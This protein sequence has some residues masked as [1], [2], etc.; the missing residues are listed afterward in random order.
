MATQAYP[1]HAVM[2]A[3]LVTCTDVHTHRYELKHTGTPM[4]CR[5][6]GIHEHMLTHT[7]AELRANAYTRNAPH[8]VLQPQAGG[9]SPAHTRTSLPRTAWLSPLHC[10][11]LNPPH[12]KLLLG[13]D[14]AG[15]NE[16][17]S[18]GRVGWLQVSPLDLSGRRAPHM[19]EKSWSFLSWD[20][21][22]PLGR[23][24]WQGCLRAPRAA[25]HV[26]GVGM[27]A[28]L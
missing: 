23:E 6:Q 26:R 8:S 9:D 20:M 10:H 28:G 5:N 25:G 7:R 15:L 21:K 2:G 17:K 16:S 13:E 12:S 11:P 27:G 3:Y 4:Q 24:R 22:A 18:W 1:P 14:L 19:S